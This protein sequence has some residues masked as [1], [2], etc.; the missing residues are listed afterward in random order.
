MKI[1]CV[2]NNFASV[3][4]GGTLTEFVLLYLNVFIHLKSVDQWPISPHNKKIS[5]QNRDHFTDTV[6]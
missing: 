1:L 5:N 3:F 4:G 6:G 2:M